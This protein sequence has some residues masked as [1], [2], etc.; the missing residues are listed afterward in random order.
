MRIHVRK[1]SHKIMSIRYYRGLKQPKVIS[2]DLD[3]TLYDNVPV[4]LNAESQLFKFINQ[5]VVKTPLEYAQWAQLKEDFRHKNPSLS[6]DVSALRQA[7]LQQFIARQQGAENPMLAEQAYQLFFQ[8]RNQVQVS[9]SVLEVLQQLKN[10]YCLVALTNG[11]A[12]PDKIGLKGVFKYHIKPHKNL[13][14][15]PDKSLFKAMQSQLNV[16]AQEILHL[17][18]SPQTDVSGALNSGWQAGWFN[19]L[20]KSYPGR[21]LPHFEYHDSDDLLALLN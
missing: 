10:H 19:P 8:A 6:H 13:K 2:F 15:K 14:M 3:D 20:K 16:A 7:F 18:D 11:N 17:G 5:A 12:E 1:K 9:Q 4:I 21:Q